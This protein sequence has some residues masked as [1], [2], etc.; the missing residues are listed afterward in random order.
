MGLFDF[1]VTSKDKSSFDFAPRSAE[2]TS[3]YKQFAG[4]NKGLLKD[5]PDFS[6]SFK[7]TTRAAQGFTSGAFLDPS[8]PVNAGFVEATLRPLKEQFKE[9]TI[10][11]LE[12]Y[13]A[14]SG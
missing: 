4:F 10:P 8:D 2:E 1:L 13:L 6:E 14:K 3:T 11:G 9:Q 5:V 12:S 7:A